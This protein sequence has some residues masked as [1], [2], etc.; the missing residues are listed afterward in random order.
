L[1]NQTFFELNQL[2]HE[3]PVAKY[4]V[5]IP[6]VGPQLTFIYDGRLLPAFLVA[7]GGD[8]TDYRTFLLVN[9]IGSIFDLEEGQAVI[10]P[11]KDVYGNFSTHPNV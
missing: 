9:Q 10:V 1:I 5:P 8:Y 2:I 7:N 3:T 4:G 6:E 11:Q